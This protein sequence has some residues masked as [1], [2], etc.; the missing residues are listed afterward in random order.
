MI[1][2]DLPPTTTWAIFISQ[3]QVNWFIILFASIDPFEFKLEL[4]YLTRLRFYSLQTA[5]RLVTFDTTI[6]YLPAH[7]AP[8]ILPPYRTPISPLFTSW[9]MNTWTLRPTLSNHRHIP[10]LPSTNHGMNQLR[11]GTFV[12]NRNEQPPGDPPPLSLRI[13][14][15]PHP[16]L[17]NHHDNPPRPRP[18]PLKNSRTNQ[19]DTSFPP[20]NRAIFTLKHQV[21][22]YLL[23]ICL[24]NSIDP[25]ELL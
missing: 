23:F 15:T 21:R 1:R 17:L 9:I 20:S 19:F 11:Y 14:N 25:L 16:T 4:L 6:S 12:Y 10:P 7:S 8:P 22:A 18:R 5:T 2:Y 13:I 3:H 24:A